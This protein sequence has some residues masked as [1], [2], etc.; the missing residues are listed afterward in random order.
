MPKQL[1]TCDI[2]NHESKKTI[3]HRIAC[4]LLNID[5]L[6][7]DFMRDFFLS[8][9]QFTGREKKFSEENKEI[10]TNTCASLLDINKSCQRVC[11]ACFFKQLKEISERQVSNTEMI[12]NRNH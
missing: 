12:V 6:N 4:S 11:F 1:F 2:C 9:L 7:D 10:I 8:A 3:L 5:S